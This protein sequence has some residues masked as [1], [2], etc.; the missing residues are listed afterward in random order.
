MFPNLTLNPKLVKTPKL[1]KM[2]RYCLAARHTP[3][4]DV[5]DPNTSRF[6]LL[7]ELAS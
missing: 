6:S 2:P 4:G 7:C 3:P 5:T 1:K